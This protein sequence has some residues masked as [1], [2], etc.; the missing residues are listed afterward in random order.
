MGRPRKY[1]YCPK[2]RNHPE[3]IVE[4]Y[5]VYRE[6]R[7]WNDGEYE[8]EYTSEDSKYVCAMCGSDLDEK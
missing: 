5:S 7:K 8:V 4:D 3:E 1:L 6:F 2:C